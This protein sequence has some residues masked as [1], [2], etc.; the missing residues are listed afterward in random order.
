MALKKVPRAAHSGRKVPRKDLPFEARV[1]WLDASIDP[2]A[3]AALGKLPVS[4]LDLPG[5]LLTTRGLL[6]SYGPVNALLAVDRSVLAPD[7][8]VRCVQRIPLA[9]IVMVEKLEP[10]A[11]W[12][13]RLASLMGKATSPTAP[14]RRASASRSR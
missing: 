3:E 7:D 14:P 5:Q 13:G 11:V 8:E 4:D 12:R 9:L 1:T 6:L 2:N 10:T